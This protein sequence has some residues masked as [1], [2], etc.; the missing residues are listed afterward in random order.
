V[1]DGTIAVKLAEKT[2]VVHRRLRDGRLDVGL[3]ALPVD[4]DQLHAEV[5]FAED[6]V[7]AGLASAA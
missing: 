6:F 7:L 1:S 4:D 2:E 5:L 3:M